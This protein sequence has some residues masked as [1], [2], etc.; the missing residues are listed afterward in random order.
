MRKSSKT[1]FLLL[2]VCFLAVLFSGTA[3]ASGLM[4]VIIGESFTLKEGEVLKEDLLVIGGTAFL[5]KGSKVAGNIFVLGGSLE[6]GGLV[7]GDITATGGYVR[8][9]ETAVVKGNVLAAGADVDQDEGAQVEGEINAEV[10]RPFTFTFPGTGKIST[11][12]VSFAPFWR[13]I[14]F[15]ARVFILSALAVLSAMF[16]PVQME[17]VTQAVVSQ[18]I[19]SGGLGF[20]TFLVT[21]LVA[22]LMAITLVLIPLS[23][24]G[25]LLVSFLALFGWLALGLEVGKRLGLAF[26]QEWTPPLAAGVGTFILTLILGSVGQIPCLGWALTVIV[27]CIGMGAVLLTRLGSVPSSIERPS[28]GPVVMSSPEVGSD[29]PQ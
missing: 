2:V 20:L 5:E 8:L 24:L 19:I 9:Y 4:R 21:P 14:A 17:R 12:R 27:L 25:V 29:E 26:K 18:P 1:I 16:F 6:V 13:A 23:L 11:V 10:D 7:E 3:R 15:L 22:V 28:S